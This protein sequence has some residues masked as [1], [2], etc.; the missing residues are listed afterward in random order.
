MKEVVLK[1]ET[2]YL[3][4]QTGKGEKISVKMHCGGEEKCGNE[5]KQNVKQAVSCKSSFLVTSEALSYTT[6]SFPQV[7]STLH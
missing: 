1:A 6:Q 4:Q 3:K 5:F 2:F 7:L